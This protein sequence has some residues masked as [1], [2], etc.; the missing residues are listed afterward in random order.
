MADFLRRDPLQPG[1]WDERFER[2]F[3]PWDQGGVPL[4]LRDFVTRSVGTRRTLIPG[5]GAAYELAFLSNM[6]W[7]TTAIDF[8]LAAVALAKVAVGPWAERVVKADFFTWQPKQPIE[9]IYERAFMCALPRAMWPQLAE[10][11]AALL[12]PS[13]LLAGSFFFD[14][15][16]KGPP[17]GLAPDQLEQLLGPYFVQ[18]EDVPVSDSIAVFEGKERW[19]VWQRRCEP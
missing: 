18:L 1:F 10:R 7:D 13:A 12:A 4:A 15:V 11:Y 9:L 16:L 17:F 2:G 8:S 6:G 19:Q 3:T 5:C 14:D